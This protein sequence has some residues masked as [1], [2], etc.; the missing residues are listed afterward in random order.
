MQPCTHILVRHLGWKIELVK[1]QTK[2]HQ[3]ARY[4]PPCAPSWRWR[5]PCRTQSGCSARSPASGSRAAAARCGPRWPRCQTR[6]CLHG[7]AGGGTDVR[8]A[9][10]RQACLHAAPGA[11]GCQ[12]SHFPYCP[13][14]PAA[15]QTPCPGD[16]TAIG[17]PSY[18]LHITQAGHDGGVTPFHQCACGVTPAPYHTTHTSPTLMAHQ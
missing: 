17:T 18:Q 9:E 7:W 8:R 12:P 1:L 6:S 2:L 15:A 14:S 4:T 13:A 10:A 16:F 3:S 5:R 11:G